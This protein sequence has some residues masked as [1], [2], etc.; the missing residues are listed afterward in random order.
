MQQLAVKSRSGA[1]AVALSK[2]QAR[3]LAVVRGL[4]SGY[5]GRVL[6]VPYVSPLL[7]IPQLALDVRVENPGAWLCVELVLRESGGSG[8]APE[9]CGAW[10][11]RE[12]RFQWECSPRGKARWVGVAPAAVLAAL[13]Q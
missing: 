9:S 12:R 10:T 13:G 6:R 8:W 4:C 11:G 1:H 2:R 5:D 7:E 3:A